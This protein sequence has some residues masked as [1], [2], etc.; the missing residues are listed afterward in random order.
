MLITA[1]YWMLALM[2]SS[3]FLWIACPDSILTRSELIK[4][5]FMNNIQCLR[6]E[7]K[8]PYEITSQPLNSSWRRASM[9]F[10]IGKIEKWREITKKDFV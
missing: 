5:S 4:N 9:V 10:E 2:P 6:M 1:M 7:E 3:S 8:E